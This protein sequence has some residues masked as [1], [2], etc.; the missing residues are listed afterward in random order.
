M[1]LPGELLQLKDFQKQRRERA[2]KEYRMNAKG[3]LLRTELR[4]KKSVTETAGK[5]GKVRGFFLCENSRLSKALSCTSHGDVNFL[6]EQA[7]SKQTTN[8]PQLPP[9]MEGAN[10]D[11]SNK[12][13]CPE[14]EGSEDPK[15]NK[16]GHLQI[17]KKEFQTSLS[18]K[19]EIEKLLMV[20]NKEDLKCTQQDVSVSPSLS[21]ETRVSPSDNF[22]PFRKS[23]LSTLPP[24]PALEKIPG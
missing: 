5:E 6:K 19:E 20:E 8:P 10:L 4:S 14:S 3:L 22:H 11:S 13:I 16:K 18:L 17:P 12:V 9:I 23:V 21:Q 2:V 15:I 24:C 7:K 1:E